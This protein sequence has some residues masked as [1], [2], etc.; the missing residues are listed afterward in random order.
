MESFY[1]DPPVYSEPEQSVKLVLKN[2]IAMRAIRQRGKI[3][4]N[5]GE[6]VW[7]NLDDMEKKILAYMGSHKLVT[8]A[9]LAEYVGRTSK[10]VSGRLNHLMDLNIIRRNGTRTDPKQTYELLL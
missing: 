9:E 3:I 4:D 1:L 6:D 5:I 10:T 7:D 8:T 2:N